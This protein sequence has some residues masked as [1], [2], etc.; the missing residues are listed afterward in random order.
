MF[1][2]ISIMQC[3]LFRR[4]LFISTILLI[5]PSYC[6]TPVIGGRCS[7]GTPDVQIGGKQTQF[8]L[9]CDAM[10]EYVAIDFVAI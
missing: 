5:D 7:L 6:Q 4:L 10:S 1:L 3:H 2:R 8:F 9:R